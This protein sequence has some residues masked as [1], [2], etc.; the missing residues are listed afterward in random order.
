[1]NYL[2]STKDKNIKFAPQTTT[3]EILQNVRTILSTI[4]GSVPLDRK[5]GISGDAVDKPMQKAEAILSSE[6]FAQIRRYEP[7][8]S[9]ESITFEADISGKLSP[10][11]GVKINNESI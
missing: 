3:E 2:V 8:V 10:T 6:I 4:K 7:R 9:I 11:V 1:M 5:F